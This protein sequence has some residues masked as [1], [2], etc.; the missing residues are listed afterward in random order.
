LKIAALILG[1]L[2]GLAGFPVAIM[3]HALVGAGGGAGGSILYL[4]PL[5]C[6]LGAGLAINLPAASGGLLLCSALFWLLLGAQTGYAINI[7]TITPV[8]LSGVAGFLAFAAWAQENTS[9]EVDEPIGEM[10]RSQYEPS[11]DSPKHAP[12]FGGIGADRYDQAKWQ[13]LLKYDED[14]IFPGSRRKFDP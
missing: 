14:R 7:I 10:A 3:G 8:A 11:T 13:A 6:L 2:G 1:I 4:L 12:F 5:A 9:S